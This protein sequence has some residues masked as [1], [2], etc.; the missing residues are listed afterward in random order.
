MNQQIITIQGMHCKSCEIMLEKHIRKVPGVVGVQVNH[1]TGKASVSYDTEA[2]DLEAIEREIKSVGYSLGA[3]GAKLEKTWLSHDGMDYAELAASASIVLLLYAVLSKTGLLE[4]AVQSG[5]KLTLP[6]VLLIGLTAGISSCMALIGG[7]VLGLSAEHAVAHPEAT[8]LQNFRPHLF[9]NLGRILSYVILGGAIGALGS[10][11]SLSQSWLGIL[12]V[13]VGV[14]MFVLGLSLI[15]IFPKISGGIAF[16]PK[17]I[18]KM[19]GIHRE[20]KEYSHTGSFLLGTATFF[21]PCGFTQAMQLYAVSTGSFVQGA[22]VMGVFA[23]GTM[24]TLVGIGWLSSYV[25]G[26]VARYFFRIAGLAVILFAFFNIVNGLA[27]NGINIPIPKI[28]WSNSIG[29][30]STSATSAE[31]VTE[32]GKQIQILRMNQ[33]RA[34]YVPNNLSVKKGI[35]VRWIINGTFPY[36]CAA[37]FMVP[38]LGARAI[39]KEGENI[40]EFTPNDLGDIPFMCSMGMYRGNIQVVE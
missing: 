5:G 10:V 17:K 15:G 33:E 1:K 40:L 13:L 9:F 34:G 6:M 25:K 14:L 29:G 23:I 28:D 3:P 38:S 32:N 37:A 24:P 26:V 27:Q 20:G 31:I 11:F 19:L 16:M 39:L 18:S 21:L 12:T 2:L 35:P 4:V 8:P 30:G 36:S 22:L 7:L